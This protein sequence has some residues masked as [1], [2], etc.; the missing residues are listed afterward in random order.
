[1]LIVFGL[2]PIRHFL[3]IYFANKALQCNFFASI[4]I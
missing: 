1:M 3:P 2:K 4:G